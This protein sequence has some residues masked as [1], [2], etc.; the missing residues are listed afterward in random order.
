VMPDTAEAGGLD[1][2]K[3]DT[4]R[5]HP[6]LSGAPAAPRAAGSAASAPGRPLLRHQPAAYRIAFA[7]L[8]SPVEPACCSIS[9][10]RD[11]GRTPSRSRWRPCRASVALVGVGF[12]SSQPDTGNLCSPRPRGRSSGGT[13]RSIVPARPAPS[14]L[15]QRAET[16][17]GA[18]PAGAGTARGPDPAE[19]R[20]S[21]RRCSAPRRGLPAFSVPTSDIDVPVT[22]GADVGAAIAVGCELVFS[23]WLVRRRRRR[24]PVSVSSGVGEKATPQASRHRPSLGSASKLKLISARSRCRQAPPPSTPTSASGISFQCRERARDRRSR[25]SR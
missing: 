12:A 15:H 2:I 18:P 10:P 14:R 19:S 16:V 13:S 11:S 20:R 24:D 3:G 25:R 4:I 8:A 7:A 22:A 23:G 5:R 1:V 21:S 6:T 17:A 9:L